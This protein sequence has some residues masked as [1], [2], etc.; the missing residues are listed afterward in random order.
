MSKVPAAPVHLPRDRAHRQ[1]P[2]RKLRRTD[3]APIAAGGR[4]D[5][6][7]VIRLRPGEPALIHARSGVGRTDRSEILALVDRRTPGKRGVGEGGAAVVLQRSEDGILVRLIARRIEEALEVVAAQVVTQRRDQTRPGSRD[8]RS[9]RLGVE[10]GVTHRQR[11]ILQRDLRPA[12]RVAGHRAVRDRGLRESVR[13]GAGETPPVA[14]VFPLSVLLV[15]LIVTASVPEL[16]ASIETAVPAPEIVV[17]SMSTVASPLISRTPVLAAPLPVMVLESSKARPWLC[18]STLVSLPVI[19]LPVT[20]TGWL[21]AKVEPEIHWN[22]MLAP[23]TMLVAEVTVVVVKECEVTR[24]PRCKLSAGSFPAARLVN[25]FPLTVI[26]LLW[27]CA[28]SQMP[29]I[30]SGLADCA[31]NTRTVLLVICKPS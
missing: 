12:R 28:F 5:R 23:L 11:H 24:K 9:R 19:V 16:V 13:P 31:F 30:T 2:R 4:R 25:A 14:T 22:P 8:V 17:P 1:N 27:P 26:L 3:V 21:P 20:T 7:I 6:R 29:M 15:I 18:T 10:D